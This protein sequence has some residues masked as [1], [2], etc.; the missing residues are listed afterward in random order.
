MSNNTKDSDF[1]FIF[2]FNFIA[3][4][5]GSVKAG[6]TSNCLMPGPS[7]KI[8]ETLQLVEYFSQNL[9]K[10]VCYPYP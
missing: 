3:R 6:C 2:F 5:S 7:K 1:Y 10:T 9:M 8:S 4:A